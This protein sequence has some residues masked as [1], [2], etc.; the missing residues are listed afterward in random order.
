MKLSQVNLS[1]N[2][3]L[4]TNKQSSDDNLKGM[5]LNKEW[6]GSESERGGEWGRQNGMGISNYLQS[7]QGNSSFV[8]DSNNTA[9]A[10]PPNSNLL[11]KDG[12][13]LL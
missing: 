8:N 3:P 10:F 11:N 2:Y 12:L 5:D 9:P 4:S 7:S 6:G 1:H 13:P